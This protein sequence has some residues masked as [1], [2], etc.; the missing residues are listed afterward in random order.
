MSSAIAF[1]LLNM[2]RLLF[3]LKAF[4][5]H[6]FKKSQFV[7]LALFGAVLCLM[8]FVP[9]DFENIF[10]NMILK[11]ILITALFPVVI[12]FTK[13]EPEINSYVDKVIGVIKKK[14]GMDTA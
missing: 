4:K 10:V 6:P 2:A 13:L 14:L 1:L 12:Y 7:V 3:V 5:I 9:M 8:E 11:S